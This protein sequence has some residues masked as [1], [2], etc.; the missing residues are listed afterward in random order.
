MHK[1]NFKK[2]Y[3]ISEY[4][5]N[6]IKHQDKKTNIIYRNYKDKIDIPK[7][8]ILRDFCKKKGCNFFLSNN[9]KLA[10]KLNLDG[11]YLPSFNRNFN[12]LAYN[13]KKKFIIL[14]SV[15]SI[16]ELNIKKLQ[17]VKYFFLSSIF[18]KNENYLGIQK[19]RLFESYIKKNII[20]LGGINERNLRKLNLLNISGFAG[21]SLFK[22]KGPL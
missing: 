4:D 13:F 11:A 3:F 8:I 12:H 6:L 2:Y 19:F 9:I 10:I 7:L 16:K 1:I 20:A 5:T 14:G 17:L 15:H 21:I 22:K 18:K